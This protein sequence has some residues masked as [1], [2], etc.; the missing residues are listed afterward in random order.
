MKPSR[1][2]TLPSHVRAVLHAIGV[3]VMTLEAELIGKIRQLPE[4]QQQLVRSLVD[5]LAQAANTQDA[6]RT[7]EW[8]G[9]L[10][11]LGIDISEEEID[12]AR[13]EMWG[14]FPREIEL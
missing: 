4:R 12:Q 8:Y 3:H 9:S 14:N 5:E 6:L 10:E 1:R 11:H 13:K 2:R 7:H